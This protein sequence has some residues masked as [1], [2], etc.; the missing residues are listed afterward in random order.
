MWLP[1][2]AELYTEFKGKRIHQ[3]MTY[4]NYLLF[5]VDDKQKVSAPKYQSLM[6][7]CTELTPLVVAPK[8][9]CKDI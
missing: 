5:A 2:T 3:R 8:T 9:G 4:D 7:L 1:Q 6:A